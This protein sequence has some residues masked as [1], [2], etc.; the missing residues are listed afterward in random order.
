MRLGLGSVC[1]LSPAQ[2][3][4][5]RLMPREKR[6]GK[7]SLLACPIERTRK[8]FIVSILSERRKPQKLKT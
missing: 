1:N 7:S 4:L 8:L 6:V 2:S 3:S 5:E